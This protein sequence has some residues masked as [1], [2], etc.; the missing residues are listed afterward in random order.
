VQ[1][2]A[3]CCRTMRSPPGTRWLTGSRYSRISLNS[4]QC[5][6]RFQRVLYAMGT[7]SQETIRPLR[8][9]QRCSDR[10][11]HGNSCYADADVSSPLHLVCYPAKPRLEDRY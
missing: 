11:R 5:E 3:Q 4:N 1:L 10:H 9:A 6:G 2:V 7:A 8:L